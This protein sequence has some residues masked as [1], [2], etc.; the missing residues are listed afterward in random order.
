MKKGFNHNGNRVSALRSARRVAALVLALL[1]LVPANMVL[2]L[3]D[4]A[5]TG[6]KLEYVASAFNGWHA[7]KTGDQVGWV[8]GEYSD[9]TIE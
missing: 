7:V 8:S 4:G 6:T 3:A 1:M 2:A 5:A 9:I